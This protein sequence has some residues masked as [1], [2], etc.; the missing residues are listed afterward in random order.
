M[1]KKQAEANAEKAKFR[2]MWIKAEQ[3]HPVLTAYRHGGDIMKV[4]LGVASG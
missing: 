1:L 2:Q 4:D 3:L